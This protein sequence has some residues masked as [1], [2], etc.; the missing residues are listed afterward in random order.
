MADPVDGKPLMEKWISHKDMDIRWIC[1]ENL[2]KNRLQ[3]MD[4]Q[5]VDKM[6]RLLGSV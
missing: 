1:R 6:R 2:K 4:A 5:C 3:R